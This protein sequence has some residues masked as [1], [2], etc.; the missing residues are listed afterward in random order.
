MGDMILNSELINPFINVSVNLMN[1]ICNVKANRGQIF[2]RDST[3]LSG[4]V[5][6]IIGI[7]GEFKGQ[8]FFS[9]DES[10]A[11]KI[12]SIMMFGMEVTKLEDIAISAI[13]ELGNMIMGNVSTEFSNNGVEINITPPSILSGNDISVSSIGMRTICIPLA[14]ESL[15]KIEIDIAL[16]DN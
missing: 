5:A 4:G 14:L 13:A 8:V 10:T 1:M 2:I 11:C 9:M 3:F 16:T 15:G 6:I 12:A 7:A